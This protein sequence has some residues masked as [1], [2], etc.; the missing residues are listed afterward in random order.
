M[1]EKKFFFDKDISIRTKLI[2]TFCL[3]ASLMFLINVLLYHEINNSMKELDAVYSSNVGLNELSE[4]LELIQDEVYEYLNTKSSDSL[5]NFYRNEQSLRDKMESLNSKNVDN[6][7]KML[8]KSIRNMSETYLLQAEDTLQAKRGRNVEKYKEYYDETEKY[9]HYIQT[10]I[11]NL[12]NLQFKT[13][14]DNYLILFQSLSYAEVVSSGIIILVAIV[15]VVILSL[16]VRSITRPLQELAMAA[17]EV[18]AGNFEVSLPNP[19]AM[20]EV[21]IVTAA[22]TKMVASIREYLVRLRESMESEQQMKERELLMETHLKDAQ[23]KYLQAQ[24]NPHFLFNSLNAGVQLSTMED[25]E[26]TS[27]FLEKMADFLR[28][29]VR[30]VEETTTLRE[31]VDAVDSYVYILNVRFAGDIHFEKII[32]EGFGNIPLPSMIIQPLVENAVNHGIRNAEWEGQIWLTVR[33]E[34]NYLVISVRDN[35]LGMTKERIQEILECHASG[36]K[37]ETDST[38]IGLDNVIHRMELYFNRKN[39]V[40]IFSDGP[41]KGTEVRL[42][43]P[44][45]KEEMLED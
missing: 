43:I 25:A 16:M 10:A 3:T 44:Y 4:Y 17:N 34:G 8:E 21:G 15:T 26:Q 20:D 27:I 19:V 18:A 36:S 41:D 45:E 9:Y 14:S 29:N 2:L 13:N 40:Q 42:L 5:E 37:L 24:I 38:G 35:G 11:Y 23:L 12:N 30:K 39:L 7:I 28:Y 22:F 1:A 31:E 6:S 33:E 32:E